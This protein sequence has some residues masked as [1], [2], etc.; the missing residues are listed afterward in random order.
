[1]GAGVGGWVVASL[2]VLSVLLILLLDNPSSVE[3]RVGWLCWLI[4]VFVFG[5]F[6]R[7]VCMHPFSLGWIV[8]GRVWEERGGLGTEYDGC[9]VG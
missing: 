4:R 9:W 7:Q 1:M 3:P 2:T 8:E 6:V 5:T